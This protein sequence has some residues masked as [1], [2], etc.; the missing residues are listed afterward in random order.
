MQQKSTNN[1]LKINNQF[2]T[3]FYKTGRGADNTFNVKKSL[4]YI[5]TSHTLV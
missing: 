3:H 1:I 5:L 4:E 2:L